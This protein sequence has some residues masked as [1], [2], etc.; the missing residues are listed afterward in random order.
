MGIFLGSGRVLDGLGASRTRLDCT[1]DAFWGVRGCL[2]GVLQAFWM[3]WEGLGMV[4]GASWEPFWVPLG[5]LRTI[6]K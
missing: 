4:L 5:T 3:S 6:L 1:S 2:G